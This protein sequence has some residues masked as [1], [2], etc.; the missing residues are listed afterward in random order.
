MRAKRGFAREQVVA[1]ETLGIQL[2]CAGF[3]FT[4]SCLTVGLKA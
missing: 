4:T 2:A 3:S 1:E